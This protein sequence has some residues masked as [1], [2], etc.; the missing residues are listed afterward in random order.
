M[1]HNQTKRPCK[2]KS[3]QGLV[4]LLSSIIQDSH[5]CPLRDNE[6]SQITVKFNNYLLAI[7]A[8]AAISKRGKSNFLSHKSVF[9][10]IDIQITTATE[11]ESG[12]GVPF[13]IEFYE[14]YSV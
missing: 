8:C 9:I 12:F 7:A 2:E 14:L 5:F 13:R 1:S 6:L 3:L 11:I 4:E 10:A